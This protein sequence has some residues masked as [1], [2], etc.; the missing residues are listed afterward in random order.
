MGLYKD[1]DDNSYNFDYNYSDED[2][3]EELANKK[4]VR[5]LLEARLERKRLKEELEDY[6]G[7]LDGEFNWDD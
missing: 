4:R 6:E 2:D 3:V 5:R 1:Q 7:E